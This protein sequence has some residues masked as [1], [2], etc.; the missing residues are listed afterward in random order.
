LIKYESVLLDRK[1][2][3]INVAALMSLEEYW[4]LAQQIMLKNPFQRRKVRTKYRVYALLKKDLLE[5]CVIPSITLATT[6]RF[7][8][9]V[10]KEVQ[11]I[12]AHDAVN[13]ETEKMA[14]E[15]TA[16]AI[17]AYELLILDGLQRTYA[18][19]EAFE[20][21]RD[22][23]EEEDFKVRPVRVEIYVGMKKQGLLYR[24]LTLNTGQ[25]PMSFRHQLEIL[26]H[27]YLDP[28][29]FP[30]GIRI[31]R[32]K[33]GRSVSSP[34]TYRF[35][36]VID[37]YQSFIQATSKPVDRQSLFEEIKKLDFLESYDVRGQEEMMFLLEV[38]N[39]FVQKLYAADSEW[40]YPIGLERFDETHED[41]AVYP[42]SE[43]AN[44]VEKPFGT[45]FHTIFSKS[46]PMTG[47]GCTCSFLLDNGLYDQLTD[48]REYV[49]SMFNPEKDM[50]DHGMRNLIQFLD[51]IKATAKRYGDA[52]RGFFEFYFR[53]LLDRTDRSCLDLVGSPA[54]AYD[55]YRRKY[56]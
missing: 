22:L 48:I 56:S 12:L 17:D 47:F 31:F 19:N 37:L 28:N 54:E 42:D 34:G 9:R 25:T 50:V 6:E 40:T 24:M 46:Q 43:P 26:Y 35:S 38:Y 8:K 4:H 41:V 20:E 5:G 44:L 7:G 3:G 53:V 45:T 15:L 14:H 21:A 27:D 36:E 29:A 30:E 10:A 23:G 51:D 49:Q 52:Q 39:D 18:I 55:R 13:D 33:D 11:M 32:E 2:K 1:A 16:R